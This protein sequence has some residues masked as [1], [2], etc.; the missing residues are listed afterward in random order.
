VT[1]RIIRLEN[2]KSVRC[3]VIS[4]PFS[5]I[6]QCEIQIFRRFCVYVIVIAIFWDFFLYGGGEVHTLF[7]ALTRNYLL[8]NDTRSWMKRIVWFW[9]FFGCPFRKEWRILFCF[10][11]FYVTVVRFNK[12]LHKL[13]KIVVIAKEKLWFTWSL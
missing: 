6:K 13:D 10:P 8:R 3:C 9:E 2:Y 1:E 7:V 11:I 4:E 5:M 12:R